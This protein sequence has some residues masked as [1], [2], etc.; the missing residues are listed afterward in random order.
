M[1]EAVAE[2]RG[3]AR[4]KRQEKVG[5]CRQQQTELLAAELSPVQWQLLAVADEKGV[6][7]WLT[8]Q[9]SWKSRTVLKKSGFRDTLCIRYGTG[10]CIFII[11]I[12]YYVHITS[13]KRIR[14]DNGTETRTNVTTNEQALHR[15]EA[16]MVGH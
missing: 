9:P 1:V 13:S 6:L 2:V 16:V 7:T 14:K 10:K 4:Q 8:A 11:I 15:D 12:F 5:G 3:I